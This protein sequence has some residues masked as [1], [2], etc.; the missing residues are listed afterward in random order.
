[1]ETRLIQMSA[2][3]PKL[4]LSP[5]ADR[6]VY[7]IRLYTERTWGER[8]AVTYKAAIEDSFR[9]LRDFPEIGVERNEIFLGCRCLQVEQH[10]IY[11]HQPIDTEI[12]IDRIL[13][14]RQ[15]AEAVSQYFESI[16]E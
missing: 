6:D 3:S 9:R 14:V 15:S 16:E 5:S 8:R 10:I 4:R 12:V 1:M 2:H 11:Y 7:S 13:H